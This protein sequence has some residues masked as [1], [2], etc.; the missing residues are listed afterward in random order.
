MYRKPNRRI[1]ELA[2]E[3][4]GLPA[5]EVWYIGDQYACDVVGARNAG[6]FPV[7]YLGAVDIRQED[8]DDVCK[9]TDW[10]ELRALLER[11]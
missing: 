10:Q 2:L 3:K 1:F 4:A 6:I 5:S 8:R 9:I 7:W 11:V